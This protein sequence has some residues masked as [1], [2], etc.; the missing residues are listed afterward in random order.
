MINCTYYRLAEYKIIE[1]GDGHMWWETHSGFCT[2]KIGRCFV[3]GSILFIEPGH[4]SEEN[5]FLIGEF[6][7]QLNR[8]PKWEKTKYY[9]TSFNIVKCKVDQNR[10]PSSANNQ[11]F[12][13]P[14]QGDV[15][16]RLG[17]F[18]IIEQMHRKLLW[19]SYSK[20]WT[21]KVGKCYV[22][23]NILLFGRGEPE[24]TNII[25]KDFLERLFLLP[26][27]GKT[28][29]FCQQ[30]TL[31]SCETNT[32][33]FGLDENVLSDKNE[34][35]TGIFKK[36]PPQIESNI[37]PKTVTVAFTQNHLKTFLSFCSILVLFILKVLFW[38]IIIV[39]KA[40]KIFI[41]G[42]ALGGKRFLKWALKFLN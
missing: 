36:R 13:S 30:Y 4:T 26:T 19:K 2:V 22:D 35:D 27:W 25:K 20:R 8:L 18:E 15:S 17:K 10:K 32:I 39:L 42:C 37:K 41:E 7:D 38:L 34:D 5:G 9:C 31:Y 28:N 3:N 23:G 21:I 24:K 40:L 11:L 33:C 6:L 14:N 29:L 1:G 12:K 16:Y